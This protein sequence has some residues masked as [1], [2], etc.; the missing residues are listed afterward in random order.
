V[1]ALAKKGCALF[2]VALVEFGLVAIGVG[3]MCGKVFSEI[4]VA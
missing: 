1:L 2:D 4:V 3:L